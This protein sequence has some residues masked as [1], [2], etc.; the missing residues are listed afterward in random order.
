M[1]FNILTL[2]PPGWNLRTSKAACFLFLAALS[3]FGAPQQVLAV[4]PTP[5]LRERALASV[6]DVSARERLSSWLA[7]RGSWV[8]GVDK[9]FAL[10]VTKYPRGGVAHRNILVVLAEFPSDGLGPAAGPASKSTPGYYQRLFFSEDPNDGFISVREYF[11]EASNGRLIISGQVTSEWLDMP[12]SYAYYVDGT[13][14]GLG[15]YPRNSQGLAEAAMASAYKNFDGRMGYFD[16]DGPDG[17]ANSGDDDGYIDAVCIIH[18]ERGTEFPGAPDI[19]MWSHETGIGFGGCTGSSINTTCQPGIQ[20]GGVRGYLFF[21]VPEFNE[22]PADHAMGTYCHEFGHTLGL[23]DLYDYYGQGLGFFSLMAL[24]NYLP[25]APG[26]GVIGTRPGNFDAWSRQFLGFD[27]RVVLTQPGNYSIAPASKGGG[28]F[29]IW[30]NGEPGVEYF[31][32]ENRGRSGND[33]FMPGD[34]LVIYHVDESSATNTGGPSSYRVR[35]VDADSDYPGQLEIPIVTG[36]PTQGN[37]G[38]SRDF[39]PGSLGRRSLTESTDP[40]TRDYDG[41]DTGIRFFNLSGGTFDGTESASFDLVLG[42]RP[43]LR[44][45]SVSYQDGDDNRPDPNETGD[46]LLGLRNIGTPS[47]ALSLT[48]VSLDPLVTVL[49]SNSACPALAAGQVGQSTTPFSIQC[50]APVTAP[51][52]VPVRLNWDDGTTSATINLSITIGEVAGLSDRFESDLVTSGW[53]TAPIP[54]SIQNEWHR[55]SSRRM[56]GVAV[57]DTFSV[58]LGSLNSLGTGS[59]EQ[60]T[61]RTN[62]DAEL[63]SPGFNLPANS[64]LSFW[65][66]IDSETNGGFGAWDGGRVEIS[67][68]GGPWFPLEV[69]GGY[70]YFIELNAG[71]ALS[72]AS[73]IAGA[74][75]SWRKYVADLSAYNGPARI[76]FRFASDGENE[77]RDQFGGLLRY[78]EGWYLDDITVGVRQDPGP[79]PRRV[80][81]RAGP[82][83]YFAGSSSAGSLRFRFSAR[84]GLPHPG[85][86]PVVRIYDVKGRLVRALNASVDALLAN[87]F[88]ASWDGRDRAGASAGAGVYFAK[89]TLLGET[90]TTRLV[91]VR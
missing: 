66:W 74:S 42:S 67:L 87:E 37:Y 14:Y 91:V 7:S 40:N 56:P 73:T 21:V 39:W 45:A 48:L 35:V 89:V 28:S 83:P 19:S 71:T 12:R 65:S 60:Q 33:E 22:F 29:Q 76:R 84:D 27:S 4:A 25:F 2:E 46:L 68:S 34:G 81:F 80:T 52:A 88:G 50:G 26:E 64:Q 3:S 16:N 82:V 6:I 15:S 31:L 54:P 23:P 53:L 69:D 51:R 79:T 5:A 62:Q 77:P 9:S 8:D 49:Q 78:Y 13:N 36:D 70:P 32:V 85:E 61:Y 38:D 24:G 30:R 86:R 57:G 41:F 10:D 47:A 18:P 59:N 44:L 55:T 58:K 63:V 11:K 20:L 43:E 75:R 17:V 1:S 72:G 90:Q